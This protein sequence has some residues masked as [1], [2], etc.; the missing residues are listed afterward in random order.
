MF[1]NIE[2][3]DCSGKTTITSLLSQYTGCIS[4]K[5]PLSPISEIKKA[6]FNEWSE[7]A[8]TF[9]FMGSNLEIS[10]RAAK[11]LKTSSLV[12]VDRYIWS[13][14]A[15]HI[16]LGALTDQQAMDLFGVVKE[17]LVMPDVVVYLDMDRET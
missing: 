15:Y 16:A 3:V 12:I 17:H 8:R 7:I 14:L 6:L 13:T 5:S 2:G 9:I 4:L 10:T 1:I 11:A